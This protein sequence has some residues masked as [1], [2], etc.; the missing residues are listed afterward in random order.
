MSNL[1][2]NEGMRKHLPKY[3]ESH[4]IWMFKT[5]CPAATPTG[6]KLSHDERPLMC[7]LWPYLLLPVYEDDAKDAHYKLLLDVER[8]PNWRAYGDDYDAVM[9]EFENGRKEIQRTK[10]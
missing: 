8:C 7:R 4:D 2:G 1:V 9:Q 6:C 3:Y 5:G 10:S